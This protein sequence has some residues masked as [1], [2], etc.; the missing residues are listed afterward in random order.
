MVRGEGPTCEG[1]SK[2]KYVGL[3][4]I[5]YAEWLWEMENWEQKQKLQEK[6]AAE[7][8]VWVFK[9]ELSFLGMALWSIG[10][11]LN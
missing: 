5:K 11:N 7:R 1:I 9:D 2:W 6:A 4:S 10:T 3:V 8:E